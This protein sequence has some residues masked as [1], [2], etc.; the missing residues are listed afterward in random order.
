MKILINKTILKIAF[1]KS[2][3]DL[4]GTN[5]LKWS[6]HVNISIPWSLSTTFPTAPW[7]I[8]SIVPHLFDGLVQERSNS[9][10]LAMELHLS[11]TDPWICLIS[12]GAVLSS[13]CPRSP[14][15][16]YP[17]WPLYPVVGVHRASLTVSRTTWLFLSQGCP[18]MRWE[19][20]A[21]GND[22]DR[23]RAELILENTNIWVESWKCGCIVTWFCY[24]LIA[25]PGN[26]R[27]PQYHDLIFLHFLSFLS[28]EMAQVVE[29]LLGGRLGPI[30]ILLGQ[31]HGY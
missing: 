18:H 22:V 27:Q 31:C 13:R 26:K 4:W 20:A 7:M 9:S 30:L 25:K 19:L 14:A 1:C 29:I 23:C 16:L 8:A 21:G 2:L 3:S 5:E 10:A 17:W 12:L 6:V 15:S 24:Q 11:C 28:I